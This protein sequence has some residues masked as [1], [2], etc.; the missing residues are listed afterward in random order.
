MKIR[1]V[2]LQ[3]TEL[4]RQ[5]QTWPVRS[6]A[7][8]DYSLGVRCADVTFL[9]QV[10]D[11]FWPAYVGAPISQADLILTVLIVPPDGHRIDAIGLPWQRKV[12]REA[13]GKER[14][15]LWYT[16]GLVQVVRP[17]G[18]ETVLLILLEAERTLLVLGLSD[19][20]SILYSAVAA[21]REINRCATRHFGWFPMHASA[22]EV[23]GLAFLFC[24]RKGIGKTTLALSLIHATSLFRLLDDDQPILRCSGPSKYSVRSVFPVV[25]LLPEVGQRF[26]DLNRRAESIQPRPW[27][28]SAGKMALCGGQL[29]RLL[30]GRLIAEAELAG[31]FFLE[32]TNSSTSSR[33]L[34]QVTATSALPAA[35]V[36]SLDPWLD[37]DFGPPLHL[38]DPLP[39]EVVRRVP[40]WNLGVADGDDPSEIV[41]H[42]LHRLSGT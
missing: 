3:A 41:L 33:R 18:G 37:Y 23:Q 19:R 16:D 10:A 7:G 15:L 11:Y 27:V 2:I 17:E 14:R 35:A 39:R 29:G 25:R 20:A 32:R 1:N 5:S 28:N 22:V 4:V 24:G 36:A 34:T 40:V 6:L 31:I 26:P 30:N 38:G 9:E 21:I 13:G 8:P 12:V 42:E